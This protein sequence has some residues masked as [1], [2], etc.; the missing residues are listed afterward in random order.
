MDRITDIAYNA[1]GSQVA[2]SSDD[3]SVLI[4]QP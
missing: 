2:A 1:D 3:T 4:W